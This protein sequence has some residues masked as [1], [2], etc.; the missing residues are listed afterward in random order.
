MCRRL[1]MAGFGAGEKGD[2]GDSRWSCFFGGWRE[3]CG[4]ARGG[5]SVANFYTMEAVLHI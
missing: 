5:T 4:R 2:V 1:R 3:T